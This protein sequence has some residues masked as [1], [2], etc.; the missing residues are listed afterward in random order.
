MNI[1]EKNVA[2]Q[3]QQHM[4]RNA[5]HDQVESVRGMQGQFNIRM[6]VNIMQHVNRMKGGNHR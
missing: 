3:I 2:K 4:E 6:S 5:H 1:D